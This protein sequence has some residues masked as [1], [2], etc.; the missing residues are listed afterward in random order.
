MYTLNGDI[1][2]TYKRI[3]ELPKTVRNLP[4]RA[5]MIYLKAFNSTWEKHASLDNE[6]IREKA[7]H[8]AAWAA[9]RE[10]YEKDD[11]TGAWVKLDEL[12]NKRSRHSLKHRRSRSSGQTEPKAHA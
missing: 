7:S 6:S 3:N 8:E 11:K 5:K 12:T 1:F 2:M 9:V 4:S 10:A